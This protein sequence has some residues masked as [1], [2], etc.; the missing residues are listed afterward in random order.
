M[1]ADDQ[2]RRFIAETAAD[3]RAVAHPGD[4]RG[5]LGGDAVV[6]DPLV[7][8]LNGLEVLLDVDRAEG[9]AKLSEIVD[10]IEGLLVSRHPPCLTRQAGEALGRVAA[11]LRQVEALPRRGSRSG[12][13]RVRAALRGE[14]VHRGSAGARSRRQGAASSDRARSAATR[15]PLSS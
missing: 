9:L 11:R 1:D 15:L 4:R 12:F 5:P 8:E 14:R 6:L 7:Q 2:A 13:V 10:G 3:L